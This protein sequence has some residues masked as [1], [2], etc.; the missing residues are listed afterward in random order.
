M[1]FSNR[2]LFCN[3]DFEMFFETSLALDSFSPNTLTCTTP[4]SYHPSVENF[5]DEFQLSIFESLFPNEYDKRKL[6]LECIKECNQKLESIDAALKNKWEKHGFQDDE[7][8][9]T[10]LALQRK[11]KIGQVLDYCQNYLATINELTKILTPLAIRASLLMTLSH[12]MNYISKNYEYSINLVEI[13]FLNLPSLVKPTLQELK[14]NVEFLKEDE[15]AGRPNE[16]TVSENVK[17]FMETQIPQVPDIGTLTAPEINTYSLEDIQKMIKFLTNSFL[18]S[19][20]ISLLPEHRLYLL[21]LIC[22]YI[23]SEEKTDFTDL[24]LEFLMRGKYNSNINILLTDFG[25][26]KNVEIPKWVNFKFSLYL[27]SI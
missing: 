15:S 9:L 17:K 16:E 2:R 12:K 11:Y 1:F 21:T 4:I 18:N 23:K 20:I 22:F 14:V 27:S 7:I 6:L 3:P 26:P 25:V 13:I 8:I 10:K 19:I 5:I 24:E